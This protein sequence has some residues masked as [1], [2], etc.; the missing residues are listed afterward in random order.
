MTTPL[1]DFAYRISVRAQYDELKAQR[2]LGVD[3]VDAYTAAWRVM[4]E[5]YDLVFAAERPAV[6]LPAR[7]ISRANAGWP[8]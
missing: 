6:Y 2:A 3:W 8:I 4:D 1:E 7:V 5:V